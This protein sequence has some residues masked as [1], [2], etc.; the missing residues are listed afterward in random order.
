[1]GP[2][3][4]A[5]VHPEG[6]LEH[7]EL[8]IDQPPAGRLD[9]GLAGGAVNLTQG[10]LDR[11][12]ALL[13]EHRPRKGLRADAGRVV[14]G[15]LDR[16]PDLRLLDALGQRIDRQPLRCVGRLAPGEPANLRVGKLPAPPAPLRLAGEHH[17]HPRLEPLG[18]EGHVEPD[19]SQPPVGRLNRDRQ[20]PAAGGG[21]PA[22]HVGDGA[23]HR[24]VGALD[25]IG[26]PVRPREVLVVAGEVHQ[27]VADGR[28]PQ[29]GEP[30]R[31]GRADARQPLEPGREARLEAGRG[32]GGIHECRVY[33]PPALS[34]R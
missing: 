30:R 7:E 1:M 6:Q 23:G 3:L 5:A 10:R 9:H 16:Q 4:P 27:G 20:H 18:H 29:F 21:G 31:P 32:R 33:P 26:E 14:E 13:G 15:R 28:E 25:K 17:L 19:R 12:E 8:L 24:G 22:G 11:Q 2:L 34:C